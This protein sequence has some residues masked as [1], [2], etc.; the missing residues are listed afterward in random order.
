MEE[1]YS[2]VAQNFVKPPYLTDREPLCC[3]IC[4]ESLPKKRDWAAFCSS[5]CAEKTIRHPAAQGYICAS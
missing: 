1:P 3:A 2:C 5:R 4:G